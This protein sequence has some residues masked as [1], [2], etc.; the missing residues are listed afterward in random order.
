MVSRKGF[1]PLTCGLGTA[2]KVRGRS[3]NS[4]TSL[5]HPPIDGKGEFRTVGTLK[6]AAQKASR[7]KAAS[8]VE[9]VKYAVYDGQR[10]LGSVQ[11][12]KVEGFA[13]HSLSGAL[14]ARFDSVKAAADRLTSVAGVVR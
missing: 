11:G 13:A 7:R 12:S 4:D 2:K 8:T 10:R 6:D 3:K 14:V 1:E 5:V 9:T